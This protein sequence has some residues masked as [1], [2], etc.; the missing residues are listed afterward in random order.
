MKIKLKC[1]REG[2]D[3][4]TYEVIET[5]NIPEFVPG[6]RWYNISNKHNIMDW[7]YDELSTARE[8]NTTSLVDKID[9]TL[10]HG[11]DADHVVKIKGDTHNGAIALTTA[12]H[13]DIAVRTDITSHDNGVGDSS[14]SGAGLIA[15]SLHNI[16][17]SLEEIARRIPESEELKNSRRG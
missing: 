17:E 9:I 11:Y 12:S 6:K 13:D 10:S 15:D 3:L 8:V 16:S 14:Y 2:Q 7:I 5:V 4:I 1:Y